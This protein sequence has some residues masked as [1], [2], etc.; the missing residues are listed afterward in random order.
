ML[1]V[2]IA[3]FVAGCVVTGVVAHRK[4]DLFNKAVTV[5]NAVDDKVNSV[6]KKS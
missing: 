3:S 2:A 6:A 5:V 1:F 4:P